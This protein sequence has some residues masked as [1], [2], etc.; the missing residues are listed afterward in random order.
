MFLVVLTLLQV[1]AIFVRAKGKE[2][3]ANIG[4]LPNRVATEA[5]HESTR[6]VVNSIEHRTRATTDVGP[7][8]DI[9]ATCLLTHGGMD[10]S[11][12]ARDTAAVAGSAMKLEGFASTRRPDQ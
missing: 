6:G 8:G 12:T 11:G 9:D 1:V 2:K 3:L 5:R 7:A 10:C 4:A